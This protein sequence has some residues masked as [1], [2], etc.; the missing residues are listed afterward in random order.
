MKTKLVSWIVALS[1]LLGGCGGLGQRPD[2]YVAD[3]MGV[4]HGYIIP[5]GRTA[6]AQLRWLEQEGTRYCH[7]DSTRRD[8]LVGA[9]AGAAIGAVLGGSGSRA[10]GAVLGGIG[11]GGLA[12][13]SIAEYCSVLRTTQGLVLQQME[14]N[15][16]KSECRH[17]QF[18]ENGK[19][20]YSRTDCSSTTGA[21]PG[22]QNYPGK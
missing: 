14:N 13:M 12:S 16:P 20:R 8:A 3:R 18:E 11:G 7:P 17:Q 6:E 21:R 4:P 5:P 19:R 9:V 10:T 15:K 2:G 22:Y 1:F